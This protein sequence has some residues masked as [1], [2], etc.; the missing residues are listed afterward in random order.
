M[1]FSR[2]YLEVQTISKSVLIQTNFHFDLK[3]FHLPLGPTP[4]DDFHVPYRGQSLNVLLYYIRA[5]LLII[6]CY[7]YLGL[8][9]SIQFLFHHIPSLYFVSIFRFHIGSRA[10][11]F[12]SNSKV[13]TYYITAIW[14]IILPCVY[15][16]L[17]FSA[18]PNAESPST[19]IN[20]IPVL[21]IGFLYFLGRFVIGFF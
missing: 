21:L 17:S 15:S 2:C 14:G 6:H 5:S 9:I 4:V 7:Q 1:N 16:S 20:S 8:Y 11:A 13:Y 12:P 10:L 3:D 19:I 18:S